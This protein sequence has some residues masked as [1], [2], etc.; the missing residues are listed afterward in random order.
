[1]EKS[2]GDPAHQVTLLLNQNF[3]FILQE[4]TSQVV[5]KLI[6][7]R[8]FSYVHPNSEQYRSSNNIAKIVHF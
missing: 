4:T 8:N 1:M 5:I 7:A 6:A 2:K 3:D